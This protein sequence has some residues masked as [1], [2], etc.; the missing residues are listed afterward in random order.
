MVRDVHF[1]L[2]VSVILTNGLNRSFYS[3]HDALDYLENEWPC[4]NKESYL[5]ALEQCRGALKR[6]ISEVEAQE[7]FF[8]ACLEAGFSATLRNANAHPG[9]GM[10]DRKPASRSH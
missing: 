6:Q 9:Q 8:A 10:G 2:P 1:S 3:V 7:A 5:L 4:R